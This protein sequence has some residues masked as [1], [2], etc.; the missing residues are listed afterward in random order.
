MQMVAPAEMVFSAEQKSLILAEI[1]AIIKI[2]VVSL[3]EPYQVGF[4][5]PVVSDTQKDSDF[6]PVVNLMALN[7]FIQE[8]HFKLEKFH[9][10]RN[11]VRQGDWLTKIYLKDAYFLIPVHPGHQKFLQFT[12]KVSLYQLYCLAFGLSGAP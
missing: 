3:Q 11:L 7:K 5:L 6:H 4:H 9:M 1:Q 12:W 2:G 10:V 8:E